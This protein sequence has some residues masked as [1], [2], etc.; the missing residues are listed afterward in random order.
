MPEEIPKQFLKNRRFQYEFVLKDLFSKSLDRM[1]KSYTLLQKAQVK[2]NKGTEKDTKKLTVFMDR[3][4][5][6]Q[7]KHMRKDLGGFVDDLQDV[8]KQT[9]KNEAQTRTWL[10][11]L[12]DLKTLAGGEDFLVK[13]KGLES[14]VAMKDA[15]E[16][17]ESLIKNQFDVARIMNLTIEQSRKLTRM[18]LKNSEGLDK[19]AVSMTAPGEAMEKLVNAGVRDFDRIAAMAPKVALV[20]TAVGGSISEIADNFY[21]FTDQLNLTDAQT[22]ET[23]KHWKIGSGSAAQDFGEMR[24]TILADVGK[25]S[26]ALYKLPG[27]TQANVLKSLGTIQASFSDVWS[28]GKEFAGKLIDA[29]AQPH[30][31]LAADIHRMT[32]TSALEWMEALKTTGGATQAVTNMM[33]SLRATNVENTA[34]LSSFEVSLGLTT[35]SM[36]QLLQKGGA[37]V[38]KMGEINDKSK[39][40]GDAQGFFQRSALN[41]TSAIGKLSNALTWIGERQIPILGISILRMKELV[42]DL[43]VGPLMAFGSLLG[44]VAQAAGPIASMFPAAT[45]AVTAYAGA[46]KVAALATW[47]FLAPYLLIAAKVAL[48]AGAIY[49]LYTHWDKLTAAMG[50]AWA[51]LEDLPVL[52]GVFKVLKS[53]RGV[54]WEVNKAIGALAWIGLKGLWEGLSK[55]GEVFWT[56]FKV[57]G[58]LGNY[59]SDVVSGV[60]RDI[61]FYI[62]DLI[63]K[64]DSATKIILWAKVALESLGD[65]LAWVGKQIGICIEAFGMGVFKGFADVINT[66]FVGPINSMLAW[67]IPFRKQ[68]LGQLAGVTTITP[69]AEGGLVTQPTLGV[70]GEA[71]PEVVAPLDDFIGAISGII[72][73]VKGSIVPEGG[74][75]GETVTKVYKE[76]IPEIKLSQD[77]VVAV[78][79]KILY[80]VEVATARKGTG[81][82]GYGSGWGNSGAPF[83]FGR[84]V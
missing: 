7:M 9:K 6:R 66:R 11:T 60:F 76:T 34:Q 17:S 59:L 80:V 39:K 79:N 14:S 71:G 22:M 3:L 73:S 44:G 10:D 67:K 20:A 24:Q 82:A 61:T 26:N 2:W 30:S 56:V 13:V 50:R 15:S 28:G 21:R 51:Y 18:V 37:L 69:L 62:S 49:L 70:V 31:Q 8:E 41:S 23:F 72:G 75:A 45:A 19:W 29:I 27:E 47:G 68:T 43:P 52:G 42:A 5:H 38:A 16:A 78:L 77:E 12:R 4:H 63:G 64:S 53:I 74:A 65:R 32:G 48:V 36:G 81:S 25:L 46:A 35:G 40:A 54:V 33:D 83:L 1:E 58:A 55:V 57:A 84:T